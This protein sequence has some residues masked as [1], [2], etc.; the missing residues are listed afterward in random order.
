MKINH[1][2]RFENALQ[3]VHRDEERSAEV[4]TKLNMILANQIKILAKIDELSSVDFSEQIQKLDEIISD[5][6]TTV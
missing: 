2:I 3:L 1:N 6:K 5:I 4:S